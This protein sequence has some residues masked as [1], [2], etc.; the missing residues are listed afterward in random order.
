MK[1]KKIIYFKDEVNDD[2][3]SVKI[4]TKVIDEKYKY[5]HRS[6]FWNFGHF[7][8]YRMIATPMAYCYTKSKFKIR[9]ENK[10]IL[11]DVKG[12]FFLFGNHTQT[13]GDAFIP[14]LAAFPKH[15]Y[16]I[17]HPD[18]VSI[19]FLGRVTP[20]MGALPLP[21]NLKATKNFME[22]IQYRIEEGNGILIYPEA[23]VWPYYTKIRPFPSTSFR[24]PI[25]F[26][27]PSFSITTTYQ[28]VG[29]RKQ[30]VITAYID[31]PFYPNQNLEGKEREEDLRNQIYNAMV[32]RAT[33]STYEFVKYIKENELDD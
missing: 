4:N 15:L 17:V 6:K 22:A 7:F 32:D 1:E 30:P 24:Y 10:K 20:Q 11:Q 9:F 19:P 12:G 3:S 33:H 5:L 29:K 14:N 2:F 18:N 26:N 28:K 31:G 21:S 13:I 23:H 25:K 8:W 16:I 27:V